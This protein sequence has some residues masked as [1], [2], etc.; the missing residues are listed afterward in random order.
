MTGY[1]NCLPSKAKAAS[2]VP[3]LT[4]LN[5]RV[6]NTSLQC[7]H[8]T[9]FAILMDVN[10]VSEQ[11]AAIELLT[12][13]FLTRSGLTLSVVALSI[14]I[15]AFSFLKNVKNT[16]TIIHRNLRQE[17][18][19]MSD[20]L[21]CSSLSLMI[22]E[23]LFLLGIEYREGDSKLQ[24]G[25][26]AGLLHY[27]FLGKLLL[28]N[29]Q[30]NRNQRHLHGWHLKESICIC[31]SIR[32]SMSTIVTKSAIT[33]ASGTRCRSWLFSSLPWSNTSRMGQ[34]LII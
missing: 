29:N 25:I 4:Q 20:Q 22:A 16:R 31:H 10:A 11:L 5:L 13:T 1:K 27:T 15:L 8:L 32:C 34:V 2:F 23:V 6:Y 28:I 33:T 21:N 24:C 19:L 14:T 26:V 30:L 18:Q 3:S 17:L 12:L 7:N 9:H